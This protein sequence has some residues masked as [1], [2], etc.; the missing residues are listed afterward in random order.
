VALE[1]AGEV[2]GAETERVVGIVERGAGLHA[3]GDTVVHDV[4]IVRRRGGF[5]AG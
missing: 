2:V 5:G 1:E 3:V 4:P